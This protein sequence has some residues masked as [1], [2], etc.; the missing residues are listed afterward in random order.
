M[1]IA[2]RELRPGDVLTSCDNVLA[3][4]AG[5]LGHSAIAVGPDQIVEAV[6]T[7]PFV[8]RGPAAN[9]FA[10]HPKHAHYRPIPGWL[11]NGAARFAADYHRACQANYAR[12]L[13]IPPFSFSPVTPLEDPWSSIYC[14]KLVW[15]CFYYGAGYPLYNDYFLF[16]PED[17]DSVLG[18]DP[19]FE[20]VYR[21]PEFH[22]K[23]DT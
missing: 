1:S 3:V 6:M 12:G 23:I 5:F 17:L 13:I 19:N 2:H 9:F 14:S 21:H 8:R 16:T 20:R 22:F 11:A 15:L 7:F 10:Q 18:S 4:P